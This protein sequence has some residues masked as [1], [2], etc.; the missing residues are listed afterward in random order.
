MYNNMD[1]DSELRIN[2]FM[3]LMKCPTTELLD[4]IKQ[5]LAQEEVNQVGS[6]VWTFLTN[7]QETS[8][9][10]KQGIA[11]ILGD[12][13]LQKMFDLDA[14]KFSRNVEWS[15]FSHLLNTGAT[16]ESNVIMSPQ[17]YIPRTTSLN[18]TIDMFGEAIN[19]FEVGRP[20]RSACSS[21]RPWTS[22]RGLRP[23]MRQFRMRPRSLP[24]ASSSTPS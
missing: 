3:Q 2:S 13:V 4:N 19:L 16:L 10:L 9:P 24:L 22:C 17:S 15:A 14:R 11:D 1:M 21:L 18:V 7:I 23:A 8:D 6:F 20:T 12:E 5:T